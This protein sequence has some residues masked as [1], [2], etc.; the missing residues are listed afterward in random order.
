[1]KK[2][3]SI[4]EQLLELVLPAAPALADYD[5]DRLAA[6]LPD[7]SL[8][9]IAVARLMLQIEASYDITIPDAKLTP[10]NFANLRAIERLVASLGA[11]ADRKH[12]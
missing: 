5:G 1:M 7:A 9:S 6:N 4:A 3:L 8:S 12:A 11:R 2:E 10:E